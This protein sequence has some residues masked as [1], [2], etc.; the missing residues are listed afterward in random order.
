MRERKIRREDETLVCVSMAR[1]QGVLCSCRQRIYVGSVI[2]DYHCNESPWVFAQQI[3]FS[4]TRLNV[5]S[6]VESISTMLLGIS[7]WPV[8]HWCTV[9]KSALHPV[10]LHYD[11][12]RVKIEVTVYPYVSSLR[13]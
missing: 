1:Y 9:I 7:S 3:V 4:C 6:Q 5:L 11:R 2:Y 8:F 13:R 10:V 12:T